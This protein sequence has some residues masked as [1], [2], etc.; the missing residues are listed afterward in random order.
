M[1]IIYTKHVLQKCTD[2]KKL[3]VVITKSH[4]RSV[5]SDPSS[6]DKYK[7]YPKII[8]TGAFDKQ[9]VLR[10]VYKVE[11]DII[12]VITCYPTRKGRYIS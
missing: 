10:V 12:T 7:D 4:I 9:H 6:V 1:R 5:L 3:G 2:L 11:G 8:V